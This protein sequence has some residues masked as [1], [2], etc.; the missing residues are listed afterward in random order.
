M[1]SLK[2]TKILSIKKKEFVL[3][4]NVFLSVLKKNTIEKP[5]YYPRSLVLLI[6][7]IL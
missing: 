6:C 1:I 2:Y 3:N 7:I 5:I 4:A